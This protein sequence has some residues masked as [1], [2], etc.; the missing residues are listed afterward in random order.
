MPI[1]LVALAARRCFKRPHRPWVGWTRPCS[2]RLRRSHGLPAPVGAGGRCSAMRLFSRWRSLA[3]GLCAANSLSRSLP[4]TA[5]CGRCRDRWWPA[6]PRPWRA[7]WLMPTGAI[8]AAV[9]WRPGWPR[10]WP[11]SEGPWGPRA[12]CKRSGSS[13]PASPRQTQEVRAEPWKTWPARDLRTPRCLPRLVTPRAERGEAMRKPGNQE[14]PAA[15]ELGQGETA[16]VEG[17][18]HR[19]A[20][21]GLKTNGRLRRCPSPAPFLASWLPGFLRISSCYQCVRMGLN[22]P[23]PTAQNRFRARTLLRYAPIFALAFACGVANN[24]AASAAQRGAAAAET[25]G[26]PRAITLG[27]RSRGWPSGY[28][29]LDRGD[30]E[31]R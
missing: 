24:P 2:P 10:F 27:K 6:R 4:S 7:P 14:A 21:T 22:A 8:R 29:R 1:W 28:C 25:G 17:G 12:V 15:R 18:S 30:E 9:G 11:W 5:W 13:W 26:G 16:T 3:A 19:L 20:A 31:Q 23:Q